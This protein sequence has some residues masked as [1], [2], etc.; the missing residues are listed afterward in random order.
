MVDIPLLS[1][2]YQNRSL[3]ASAQRCVNLF[4]ESNA[5]NIQAE[6]PVTHYQTPGSVLFGSG[7]T[8][9]PVRGVY[10]TTLGTAFCVISSKLFF[11]AANGALLEIGTIADRPTQVI[12]S[13]NGVALVVVDGTEGWVVELGS[14]QFHQITDT[15]FYGADFVLFLDTFFVFNRPNT[16]QFYISLSMANYALLSS[17]GIESGVITPGMNYINGTYE[18]VPLIGGNGIGA[19]ATFIVGG[20]GIFSGNITAAG[21]GYVNGVYNTVPLTG[22]AGA[23]AQANI[24]VGGSGARSGNIT[25]G[26]SGY[27]N[28]VTAGIA[29]TGGA[30]AG[31]IA[32]IT[33]SG[34]SVT[35]VTITTPGTG[36]VVGNVLAAAFGGGTGFQFT[37][38]TIGGVITDIVI[39]AIGTGYAIGNVLS[40]SN[41]N[42]GGA[43]AGFQFTLTDI[44]GS[45]TLVDITDTGKNYLL[46]DVLTVDAA[47][48]GGAGTG[49]VYTL[50]VMASAFDPLDIAAKSGSA[51]PIVGIATTHGELWLIGELTTEVWIGTGAGDFYFQRVQGAFIEH[52]S[53]ATY[54]ITTNDTLVFFLSQNKSGNCQILKAGNYKIEEISTPAIVE[55]IKKYDRI[56]D[57]I[58]FCF[59]INDHTYYVIVFPTGNRTW[60]YDIGTEEWFEWAWYD[61]EGRQNRHRSNCIMFAFGKNIFG[62]FQNGNL[63]QLRSD[64]ST[65]DENPI[66]RIRTFPHMVYD[67]NQVTYP[68]FRADFMT[69]KADPNDGPLEVNLKW[70]DDKGNTYGFPIIQEAGGEAE[71]LKQAQWRRLGRARDRVF[72]LSWSSAIITGLSGAYITK[73]IKHKT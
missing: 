63:Y 20:S 60:V 58:G 45:V 49:F 34:G 35:N 55:E 71:Y 14:N 65:D 2:A 70:S 8:Q 43:G 61:A 32:T 22:G 25:T 26:G 27:P 72:E 53:G 64:I 11:I 18:N 24:T 36:Y 42:L 28:G 59:Q 54:S 56:D 40:A 1:G 19:K 15:L 3:I 41:V 33:V 44:G 50:D 17:T 16:N 68:C 48:L 9:N 12:M 37:L 23:G 10:R 57:A 39:T 52:G 21:N 66:V 46:G 38:T 69:V 62:D 5:K 7:P 51:D 47:N 30:G 67:G 6:M 73:P 31:A 29:L 13:D 4:P